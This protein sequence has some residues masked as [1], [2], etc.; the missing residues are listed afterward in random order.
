MFQSAVSW[1]VFSTLT[2]FI[3]GM[4]QSHPAFV[5]AGSSV[6]AKERGVTDG[7]LFEHAGI[8]V[9]RRIGA[10]SADFSDLYWVNIDGSSMTKGMLAKYGVVEHLQ[11][12]VFAVM[13]LDPSKVEDLSGELHHVGMACGAV[14][15]LYGDVI[16]STRNNPN[17]IVD[18][19]IKLVQVEESITLVDQKN[20]KSTVDQLAEIETRHFNTPTGIG[21]A[22]MIA[23][24][25]TAHAGNRDD[26][27]IT[28]F[29]HSSLPQPS[30][31]VRII[32]TEFPD[33]LVLLGSHIDSINSQEGSQRRAPGADDNASGTATNLEIFR[34]LMDR[35]F[36]PKRTV[37][38]HGYAAEEI[39]LRGSQ[40][41]A[42][43]YAAN[44]KNV[45]AMVQ[46]DMNL[47][48]DTGKDK[49]WFVSNN[50]SSALNKSLINLLTSYLKVE[51]GTAVLS[52]GN[53]DHYSWSRRGYNAA[54]PFE[55]PRA[56]NRH[57]HTRH[58]TV[59]NA[60]QFSQA[61]EFAKLGI[62]YIMH[63]AGDASTK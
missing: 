48:S 62:A 61:A 21:V 58:D 54:F 8:K 53:S 43:K 10:K 13:T 2:F 63:F 29:E 55:N 39:G 60:P 45:I 49:I 47:Y 27:E 25:Y 52:G 46:Y 42:T 23:R 44:G 19:S 12:G 31:I 3:S 30:L 36:R 7:V 26:I 4:A 34:V 40:D 38:I 9:L 41:I 15:R 20:I 59:E 51:Y 24:L 32:G 56:Y 28:T 6:D 35:N 57:I 14:V 16:K 18:E 5:V 1:I 22:D 17:P 37:E 33:E 50:T 11:E